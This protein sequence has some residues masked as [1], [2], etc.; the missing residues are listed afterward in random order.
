MKKKILLITILILISLTTS[1]CTANY[2]LKYEKGIFTE[3]IEITGDKE[4]DAHPTY[5]E[6]K[7][8]GLYADIDGKELFKLDEK[9][10]RY[11][12]KLSHRLKD[13][14]LD[15]LKAV[16]ECFNLSIYKETE[17]SYYLSLYGGFTCENLTN[18][19]FTLE[20][21]ATVTINNAHRIEG[22]KYIW[23][24]DKEKLEDGIKFQV[25]TPEVN[26]I[27]P[28]NDTMLPTWAKIL[29]AFVIIG[30]GVGLIFLLKRINER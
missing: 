21:D 28:E 19:T 25:L 2:T 3:Y 15:K 12:V 9:S 1:G 18:S 4:D 30:V 20:T 8:N 27:I 29:L 10:T 5:N 23:D 7:D 14:S 17:N 16:S 11:D 26:E 13:V 22:N 6:I 24:L